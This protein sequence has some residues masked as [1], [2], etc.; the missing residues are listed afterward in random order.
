M[1]MWSNRCSAAVR[2]LLETHG[3]TVIELGALVPRDRAPVVFEGPL[4]LELAQDTRRSADF[5]TRQQPRRADR[6]A[7]ARTIRR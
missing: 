7:R 5:R 4:D 1:V 2:A 6:A 3:E